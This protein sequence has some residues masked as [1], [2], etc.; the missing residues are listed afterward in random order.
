MHFSLHPVDATLICLTPSPTVALAKPLTHVNLC[1]C[2]YV[3]VLTTARLLGRSLHEEHAG[4]GVDQPLQSLVEILFRD[5]P[6]PDSPAPTGPQ[7]LHLI[8]QL[9]GMRTIQPVNLLTALRVVGK[10]INK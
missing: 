8:G 7:P 2:I 6:R 1:E 9:R 10:Q 4:C 3:C 5:V